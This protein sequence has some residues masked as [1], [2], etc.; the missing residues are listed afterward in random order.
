MD[1]SSST[2][3]A[4]GVD[5]LLPD[6]PAPRQWPLKQPV[7]MRMEFYAMLAATLSLLVLSAPAIAAAGLLIMIIRLGEQQCVLRQR[8]DYLM[9]QQVASQP[10]PAAAAPQ[11][12]AGGAVDPQ[13]WLT[14]LEH[15]PAAAPPPNDAE[16]PVA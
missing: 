8:L 4:R 15:T 14:A 1:H 10:D 3:Y 2:Q 5:P 16:P 6:S 13:P 7:L 12:G 9:R 11:E